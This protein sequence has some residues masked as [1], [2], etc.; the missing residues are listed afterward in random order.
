MPPNTPIQERILTMHE[1]IIFIVGFL[2]GTI[3]G[4]L[5]MCLLQINRLNRT[6]EIREEDEGDEANR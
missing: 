3:A 2:L 6:T 4:V 1:F 5:T